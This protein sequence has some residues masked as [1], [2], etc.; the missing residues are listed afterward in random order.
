MGNKNI[1]ECIFTGLP[2]TPITDGSDSIDYVVNISGKTRFISL[3]WEA[4]DW[5]N[6]VKFFKQNKF[7]LKQLFITVHLKQVE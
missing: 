2:V 3:P 6:D 4:L 7:L 1:S 5:N